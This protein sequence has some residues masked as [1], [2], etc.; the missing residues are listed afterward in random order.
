MQPFAY[1]RAKDVRSAIQA[2]SSG[3]P[4]QAAVQ[5]LAGGTT[6]FDLMKLEVMTPGMLVDLSGLAHEFEEIVISPAG[7]R[8]GALAK[9]ATVAENAEIQR[10]YPVITQSLLQAASPQI[11]NMATLGGNVLQRTRCAYFREVDWTACNKRSPGSGCAALGGVNR[12]HAVLGT[13]EGCIATYPGDFAQALMVLD[14]EL[15][16]VGT[17][18]PRRMPIADL[19]R[20]PGATPH[21]ET[22]LQPGDFIAGFAIPSGP[23]ARR[24]LYLKVRDRA[25]YEFAAASAAVA[26]DLRDGVVRDVRIALGGV[27]TAPWRARAA[28]LALAGR[29]LDDHA[30]REAAVAAFA[31]ARTHGAN[32]DKPE[33]GRRTL[34]RALMQAVTM[35]L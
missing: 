20:Q 18:G 16:I 15:M 11:R 1:V 6:L 29:R 31:S 25:S 13:S 8:M 12:K 21:I 27:A 33:L 17:R 30:A 32:D 10:Q 7:L 3:P 2:A 23:W 22:S 14:A 24:S 4:G 9:M 19:H 26:L 34:A 28:E 5:Y 35:E